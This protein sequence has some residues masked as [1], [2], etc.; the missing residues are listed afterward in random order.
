MIWGICLSLWCAGLWILKDVGIN[1]EGIVGAV[2]CWL[3]GA[4]PLGFVYQTRYTMT[5][6]EL[7]IRSGFLRKRIELDRIESVSSALTP[8]VNFAMSREN[9]VQVN[10]RGVQLGYRISPA[11]LAGFM[12]AL[13]QACPHLEYS[14]QDLVPETS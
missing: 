7:I 6:K 5:S 2:L 4:A 3:A 11:D 10:V 14:G 8:G 12:R 1:A 9:V 13:A